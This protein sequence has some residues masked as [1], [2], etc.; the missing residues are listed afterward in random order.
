MRTHAG[1]PPRA[2]P[3]FVPA[4]RAALSRG[5]SHGR[6]AP[7]LPCADGYHPAVLYLVDGY[8]VAHWLLPDEDLTPEQLRAGV[9]AAIEDA[10]PHG[11]AGIEVFFDVRGPSAGVPANE[12]RGTV[13]VRNVPDAD[14]AIIERVASA[15]RADA[16]TVVSRDREV[17]GRSRQLGARALG[18]GPFFDLP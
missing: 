12:Y 3:R 15:E 5:R 8:N 16:F 14:A 10:V 2:V 13:T 11:A 4:R 17:A 1:A 7:L 9:L 6:G 18:P